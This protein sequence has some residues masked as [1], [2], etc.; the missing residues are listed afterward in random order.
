MPHGF[1]KTGLFGG[2]LVCDLPDNFADVRYVR[3]AFNKALSPVSPPSR[4]WG[5]AL[6]SPEPETDGGGT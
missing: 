5:S 4:L 1:R 3:P 6:E 2:A